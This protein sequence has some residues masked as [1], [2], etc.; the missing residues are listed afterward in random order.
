MDALN[1]T[2]RNPTRVASTRIRSLRSSLIRDV[3]EAGIGQSDLIA[4]WFGE[5][6]W[7]TSPIAVEAAVD[8]LRSGAHFYQSNNGMPV[9]RTAIAE[10]LKS[11]YGIDVELKRITVT[12]SGMQGLALAAQ[13]IIDPGDRVVSIE[14][15]WPNLA[16]AF[17]I[18]GGEVEIQALQIVDDRWALDLDEF[19][20]RLSPGTK[21]VLVNSPNNPTGWTLGEDGVK[22]ILEHCRRLGIWIVADDVYSRLYRGGRHAPGFLSVAEPGDRVISVNSFSKT[23]SMTGWRLGWIVA[24]AEL[25]S[26]LAALTEYNIACAPPF[27]Q[28][29]G[30]AMLRQGERE[31]ALLRQRLSAA[32]AVAAER[33]SAMGSVSFIESQGAFYCF[34]AVDGVTDSLGYAKQL[35]REARVGLAPGIAFGAM[36]EGYLRLCYAQPVDRLSEGFD[37]LEMALAK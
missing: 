6:C 35:V 15:A 11:V 2:L 30:V 5:G 29:A 16:E 28:A 8:A 36:G 21:A 23:W 17:R 9:L 33:L 32:Y 12:A 26:P 34:F 31:V 24:P 3:A 19:L 22:A 20:A 13:A 1:E 14:P 10:Y 25:E 4:L 7:Q 37:R 18:S 27:I